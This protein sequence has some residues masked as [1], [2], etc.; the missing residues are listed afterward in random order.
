MVNPT[1]FS[2]QCSLLCKNTYMTLIYLK[3]VYIIFHCKLVI[4]VSH[5]I[6][7][8]NACSTIYAHKI[9]VTNFRLFCVFFLYIIFCY[10]LFYSYNIFIL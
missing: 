3:L 1:T 7:S 5:K 6:N 10:V 8:S 4:N 2:R 9:Y